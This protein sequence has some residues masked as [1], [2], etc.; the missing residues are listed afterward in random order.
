[1]KIRLYYV[2]NVQIKVVSKREHHATIQVFCT[3]LLLS[4]MQYNGDT[5]DSTYNYSI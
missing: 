3:Y 5:C 2:A 1:M 4:Y